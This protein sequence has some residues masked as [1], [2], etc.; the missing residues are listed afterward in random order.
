MQELGEQEGPKCKA[1]T[2]MNS[3]LRGL[4]TLVCFVKSAGSPTQ[5]CFL[6]SCSFMH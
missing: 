4:F 1:M 3:V 2:H 6:L 5:I